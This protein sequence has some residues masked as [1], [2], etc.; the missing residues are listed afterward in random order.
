MKI[1]NQTYY[2]NVFGFYD[3][4]EKVNLFLDAT[5]K[6]EPRFPGPIL[7]SKIETLL[8]QLL[9]ANSR[10]ESK[11]QETV[12]KIVLEIEEALEALVSILG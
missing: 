8:F 5:K 3:F 6:T 12:I 7:I 11:D 1:S 10:V 9:D 2:Y 4:A